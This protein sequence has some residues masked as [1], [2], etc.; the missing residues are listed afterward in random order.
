MKNIAVIGAGT[1]GNGIAHVFAQK[2][3]FVKLIDVS[4][5]Q[6]N[7]AIATINKNLDRQITKGSL[8]EQEKKT[9]LNNLSTSASITEGVENAELV[10]EAATESV[11]LKLK[12]FQQLD[13][14]APAN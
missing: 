12:I 2:G 5:D 9:T 1:M 6:L 3:F 14:T 7:K 13:Q 10:V 8:T 4:P 11:D